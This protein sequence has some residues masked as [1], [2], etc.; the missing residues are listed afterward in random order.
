MAALWN[1]E[2]R[3]QF[4][5]DVEVA[6]AKAQAEM[7]LIP[8]S[9]AKAIGERARFDVH[10]IDEIEKTTRHD[11]IAFVSS[12]AK[13]VGDE[14][15]YVHYGLTSSDVLDTALSLQIQRAGSV[16]LKSL[17][18][19]ELALVKLVEKHAATLCAGRTHGMHAEPTSFGYKMAG[20]LTEVRRSMAR[21]ARALEQLK[22]GKISGAVGTF[23]ALPQELEA[24][25]CAN[26]GLR[27]ELVSTQ[28]LP[29]DRH[30]EL[31]FAF[32]LI[33]TALERLSIE[34]RHVQ[35][36]EV[37]EVREGFQKGQK[38]SSA[39]PHKR[40]P[41]GPENLTGA[42][43]MLRSYLV[44]ALDNVALWHERD[45]SHSS[46]ERVFLGDAFILA[47]Y[48]ADRMAKILV[49]LEVLEEQMAKN[50]QLSQGQLMSSHL[51]LALVKKGLSREEAYSMVQKLSHDLQLGEHLKDKA[52]KS[53]EIQ[54]CL[55]EAEVEGVFA[56]QGLKDHLRKLSARG[57]QSPTGGWL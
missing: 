50:M 7:G 9:A 29:R 39:M 6:V 45:I 1:P 21:L 38:G 15:R 5:L 32:A 11:V 33:G 20:H 4:M 42:A 18:S 55:S 47:D 17:A 40:N 51:L 25:V 8:Q 3:F 22:V 56:G 37:A 53:L 46:V 34:L 35:R 23:S 41:I 2:S 57:L 54:K 52:K 12:V 43:R 24:K 27:P 36:T 44:G 28:V 16:L 19:W 14:G 48:A 13:A 31:F 26:L 49:D 10:E 30:A